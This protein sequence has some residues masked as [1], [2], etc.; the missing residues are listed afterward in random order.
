M[1][2]HRPS[3]SP[4]AI[5]AIRAGR[6]SSVEVPVSRVSKATSRSRSRARRRRCPGVHSWARTRRRVGETVPTWL[7]RIESRRAWKSPPRGSGTCRSPYQLSSATTPSSAR[8]ESAWVRPSGRPLAWK[9]TSRSDGAS[10]GSAKPTPSPRATSA[11]EGST[12]T[13]VTSTPGT[14][15]SS[16]A[17]QQPMRP[18]PTTATRSPIIGGTSQRALTAVS[19][20]PVRTARRAG[21]PSGTRSTSSAGTTYTVWCG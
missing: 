1:V 6:S 21:T 17:R 7:P 2:W 10:A 8:R 13:S 14:R 19:T 4:S 16:R 12:S 18:A 11:R 20:G 15:P 3:W 9:T 5:R